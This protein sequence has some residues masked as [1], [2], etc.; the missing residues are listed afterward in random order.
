MGISIRGFGWAWIALA[1]TTCAAQADEPAKVTFRMAAAQAARV[2][3][4]LGKAAGTKFEV[5]ANLAKEVLLIQVKDMP[6]DKLLKR[7]ED[8]TGGKWTEVEGGKRLELTPGSDRAARLSEQ[9][10]NVEEYRKIADYYKRHPNGNYDTRSSLTTLIDPA[11]YA[12]LPPYARTVYATSPTAMQCPLPASAIQAVQ[13]YAAKTAEDGVPNYVANM[14]T[15][16]GNPAGPI[17][18]VYLIL[19]H[20]FA[21]Q[22]ATTVIGADADGRCAFLGYTGTYGQMS[23][24]YKSV[25]FPLK[26]PDRPI[27][28][29]E[30][31]QA[32]AAFIAGTPMSASAYNPQQFDQEEVFMYSAAEAT[33]G[34]PTKGAD[35]VTSPDRDDPLAPVVGETLGLVADAEQAAIVACLPDSAFVPAAKTMQSGRV[36]SA[37]I[38]KAVLSDWGLSVTQDSDCLIVRPKSPST[39]RYQ[40]LD[41]EALG[42]ALRSLASNGCLSL[43]ELAAYATVQPVE[44]AGTGLETCLFTIL[45]SSTASRLCSDPPGHGRVLLRLYGSLPASFKSGATGKGLSFRALSAGQRAMVQILTFYPQYELCFGTPGD[46]RAATMQSSMPFPTD[47]RRERTEVLASGLPG[48]GIVSLSVKEGSAVFGVKAG[49]GYAP[50]SVG[51]FGGSSYGSGPNNAITYTSS[52]PRFPKYRSGKKRT[53]RIVFQFLPEV[54]IM[55]TLTDYTVDRNAPLL[56]LAQMPKAFQDWAKES[57]ESERKHFEKY[58]DQTGGGQVRP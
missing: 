31:N 19:A 5:S 8:A 51:S 17:T 47:L 42:K 52:R 25:P 16:D 39:A 24:L 6:L 55:R 9:K 1:F 57:E 15:Y 14:P 22:M 54:W 38:M 41:R 56:T 26:N 36:P 46:L 23:L 11:E 10:A 43:D 58:G 20:S 28:L 13:R 53:I 3:P 33:A 7:I 12:A 2:L 44:A 49:G 50:V 18:K 48:N 40:R 4:E 29:S 30:N 37:T 21:G 27:T 35:R 32:Y 34:S 45:D